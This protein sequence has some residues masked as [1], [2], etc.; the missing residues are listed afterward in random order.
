[1][2][3]LAQKYRKVLKTKNEWAI[4][5]FLKDFAIVESRKYFP[6]PLEWYCH[7]VLFVDGSAYIVSYKVFDE[8]KDSID[9]FTGSPDSY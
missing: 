1:M 5:T 8:E 3:T 7:A 6:E 4:E 2:L 9:Y